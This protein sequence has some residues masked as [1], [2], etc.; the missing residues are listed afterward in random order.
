MN[1]KLIYLLTLVF[2]L[3]FAFTACSDD[4]DDLTLEKYE[5][6]VNVGESITLKITGGN[7]DYKV[8]SGDAT[9]ATAAVVNKE[10]AVTGVKAGETT[11]TVTDKENKK[12]SFKVVVKEDVAL[13]AAGSYNGEL[14][15]EIPVLGVDETIPD[16]IIELTRTEENTITLVLKDFSYDAQTVIGDITV[17]AIVVSKDGE[18]I[19][20]ADTV[21]DLTLLE[22][23]MTA[24]AEISEATIVGNKLAMKIKVSNVKIEGQDAGLGDMNISFSGDKTVAE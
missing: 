1:K 16:K 21:A 14:D 10:I 12:T 3:G 11:I 18:T 15:L 4:D 20:L 5:T 23:A 13:D 19:K 8:S 9:I 22:G 24:K 17:E 6:E 2:A 7:G